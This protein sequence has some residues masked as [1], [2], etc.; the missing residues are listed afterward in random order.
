MLQ[1]NNVARVDELLEICL[2]N[3]LTIRNNFPLE[4]VLTHVYLVT[5]VNLIGIISSFWRWWPIV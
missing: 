3:N 4:K 1:V 5:F 2:I